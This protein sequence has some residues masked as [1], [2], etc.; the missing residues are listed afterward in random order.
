M[1]FWTGFVRLMT[2]QGSPSLGVSGL[3]RKDMVRAAMS[4]SGIN[5]A[6]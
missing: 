4:R 2:T 5:E 1:I 6:L 3:F